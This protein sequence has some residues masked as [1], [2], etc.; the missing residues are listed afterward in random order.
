MD[1]DDQIWC[2]FRT[3]DLGAVSP[4]AMASGIERMQVVSGIE[5]DKGCRFAMWSLLYMLGPAPDLDVAFK[6]EG[7]REAARTIMGLLGQANDTAQSCSTLEN[8]SRR[9]S[10]N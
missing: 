1:F 5:S 7:G 8:A 9:L 6:D 2:F 10:R 3:N 4:A